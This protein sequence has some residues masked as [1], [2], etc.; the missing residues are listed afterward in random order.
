M[1]DA[2]GNGRNHFNYELLLDCDSDL[3]LSCGSDRS[4]SDSNTA[5]KK[6]RPSNNLYRL[7]VETRQKINII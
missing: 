5:A 4:C 2:N 7:R 6:I 1:P 3:G